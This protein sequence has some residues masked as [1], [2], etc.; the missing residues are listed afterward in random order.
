MEAS[1][2]LLDSVLRSGT[3]PSEGRFS[4]DGPTGDIFGEWLNQADAP[5]SAGAAEAWSD[6][7]EYVAPEEPKAAYVPANWLDA[8][9]L[10]HTE[11]YVPPVDMI[12]AVNSDDNGLYRMFRN[13]SP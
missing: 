6:E 7:E 8:M 5:A 12:S 2:I 1:S 3:A 13:I 10:E 4:A 11:S 9:A